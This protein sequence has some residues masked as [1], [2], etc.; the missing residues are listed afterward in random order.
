MA[1]TSSVYGANEA[2]PFRETDKADLQVSFYAATKKASEAMAHSYA[3]LWNITTKMFLFFTVYG[4]W[5]RPD[6]E[7]LLF[8]GPTLPARPTA[9]YNPGNLLAALTTYDYPV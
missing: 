2:M 6:M 3:N 1:S 9:D 7:Q 5:G 4:P 8:V